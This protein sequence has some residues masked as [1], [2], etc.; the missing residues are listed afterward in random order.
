[1]DRINA[2]FPNPA[3]TANSTA[4]EN[5]T[6]ATNLT[7]AVPPSVYAIMARDANL[8]NTA[9]ATTTAARVHGG[10][11]EMPGRPHGEQFIVW[12]LVAFG[13]VGV[14]SYVVGKDL[15]AKCVSGEF[16]RSMRESGA[17]LRASG[18]VL[19][20]G[21]SWRNGAVAMGR[22]LVSAAVAVK[23]NVFCCCRGDRKQPAGEG[24]E[25]QANGKDNSSDEGEE[26]GKERE[27][28][29]E[30][31]KERDLEA[32][33]GPSLPPVALG[34]LDSGGKS[35]S[36]AVPQ[37][38]RV[39]VSG[40]E[41]PRPASAHSSGSFAVGNFPSMLSPVKNRHGD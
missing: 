22:G 36:F 16:Q 34:G 29:S 28:E 21:K 24:D 19:F 32:G 37:F 30:K 41:R 17:M 38:E 14:L 25:G 39:P 40:L 3:A 2:T 6:S 9:E 20:S 33:L 23:E 7:A 11:F 27:L 4:T 12:A 31:G 35:V 1:M 13:I 10:Q 18:R 15:R 5:L 26:K 8:S